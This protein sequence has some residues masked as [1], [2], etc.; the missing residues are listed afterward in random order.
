MSILYNDRV[1]ILQCTHNDNLILM[2]VFPIPIYFPLFIK[3]EIMF[4]LTSATLE[5]YGQIIGQKIEKP[6]QLIN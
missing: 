3:I 5:R 6:Y 2:S 1:A 4:D